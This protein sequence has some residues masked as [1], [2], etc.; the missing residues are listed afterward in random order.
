MACRVT[1][2]VCLDLKGAPFHQGLDLK[3]DHF[4]RIN[5]KEV[6]PSKDKGCQGCSIISWIL[7]PYMEQLVGKS[8]EVRLRLRG[9]HYLCYSGTRSPRELIAE[10][11]VMGIPRDPDTGHKWEMKTQQ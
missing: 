10:L 9:D 7:E 5:I 6:A 3:G 4:D 8:A 11:E 1:C 2:P